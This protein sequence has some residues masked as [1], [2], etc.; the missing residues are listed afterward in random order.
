MIMEQRLALMLSEGN[1]KRVEDAGALDSIK[2]GRDKEFAEMLTPLFAFARALQLPDM[3]AYLTGAILGYHLR[4][5]D[6][7]LDFGITKEEMLASVIES[8]KQWL[9]CASEHYEEADDDGE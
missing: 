2:G 4:G 6:N 1:A 9:A 5:I 7:L 8:Q 3:D